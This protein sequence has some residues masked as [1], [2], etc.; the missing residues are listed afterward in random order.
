MNT[1]IKIGGFAAGLLV[2]FGAAA[3]VGRLADSTSAAPSTHSSTPAD[4]QHG[5][6]HD[7]SSA[8]SANSVPGGL[9]VSEQGYTLALG[10]SAVPAGPD[11]PVTF[12]ILGPDGEPVTSY[13]TSHD[14][15][16][17]LIAV[18]RDLTGFQHVHPERSAAGTWT[19]RLAL[20]P[21]AWRVFADFTPGGAEQGLTLGADLHVA[22]QYQPQPTPPVAATARVEDYTVTLGGT[23]TPGSSSDLTLRVARDGR[24]VTN[25][26]PYLGAYG[27]LVALREGDLAYLH[28][29]PAGAPGDNV[30]RPGPDV[31][32]SAAV[33]SEG[34]Y[35]LF[36][37]FRH[38]DVVRTAAF[39]ATAGRTAAAAAEPTTTPEET[40]G[41]GD[42]GHR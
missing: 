23:L 16:L 14:K 9:M 4:E 38:G 11:R 15:D 3:G 42:H 13:R 40:P 30:T 2:A 35:R 33:P 26:Q 17:H 37:D 1:A 7:S 25:L 5:D 31:T 36:F 10:D 20:T 39:T 18:R 24:P 22:G 32:F 6:S 29:H 19:T 12:R 8:A 41:H 21:G 28:V 34:R 27:H